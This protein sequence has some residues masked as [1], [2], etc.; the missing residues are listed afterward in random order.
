MFRKLVDTNILYDAFTDNQNTDKA[1][2][3]LNEPICVFEGVLYEL[4]NLLKN[5]TNSQFSI[6]T[7]QDIMDN[8]S[9]FK[10]LSSQLEDFKRALT[11]MS[12]YQTQKPKKDYSLCD[13][14]QLSLAGAYNLELLTTDKRMAFFDQSQAK[15]VKPY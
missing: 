13:A 4:A 3:V 5:T 12:K 1:I 2:T 8:P 10:I 11:I 14:V 15:V 7:I 9:M 6:D